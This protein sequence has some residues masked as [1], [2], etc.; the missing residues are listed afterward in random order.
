MS[1]T[2]EFRNICQIECHNL[3]EYM[4][5][6]LPDRMSVGGHHS[7]KPSALGVP[8]F[9]TNLPLGKPGQAARSSHGLAGSIKSS[10]PN[11][12]KI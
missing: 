4:S 9:Q 8:Y 10:H 1:G 11:P 5:E 6:I 7:K 12:R 2:V 3:P